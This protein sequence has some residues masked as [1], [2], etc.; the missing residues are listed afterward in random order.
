MVKDI[1]GRVLSLGDD[2]IIVN[3]LHTRFESDGMIIGI[4]ESFD[5]DTNKVTERVQVETLINVSSN[6]SVMKSWFNPLNLIKK[7]RT[8]FH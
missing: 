7:E 4:R 1:A 3:R 6:P 8:D 2:V 5:P